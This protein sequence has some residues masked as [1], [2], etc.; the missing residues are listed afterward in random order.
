MLILPQTG[1][2]PLK[3]SQVS[4]FSPYM[5]ILPQTGVFPLKH[6]QVSFFSP[7]TMLIVPQTGFFSPCSSFLRLVSY[8]S[9]TLRLASPQYNLKRGIHKNRE[10]LPKKWEC[11]EDSFSVQLG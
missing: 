10:N 2:F 9:N 6:S 1:V 3:H 4:F 5:L 11:Y 8:L 7:P